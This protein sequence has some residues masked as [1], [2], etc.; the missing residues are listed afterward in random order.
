MQN[1]PKASMSKMCEAV[2]V[3]IKEF[4][5]QFAQKFDAKYGRPKSIGTYGKSYQP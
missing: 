4:K 2:E 1:E 3:D 5:S